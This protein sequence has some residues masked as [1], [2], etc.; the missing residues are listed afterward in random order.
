MFYFYPD[1]VQALHAHVVS[2]G[3]DATPLHVTFYGMKEF[4]MQDPDGHMLCFGQ[5]TDEEPAPCSE[6]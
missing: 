4:S 5:E 3:I 6:E 1:D 2:Q